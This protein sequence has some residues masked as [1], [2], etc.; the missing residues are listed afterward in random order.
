[1][2]IISLASGTREEEEDRRKACGKTLMRRCLYTFHRFGSPF[3]KAP[4]FP[5]CLLAFVPLPVMVNIF[6]FCVS[7]FVKR[8]GQTGHGQDGQAVCLV[9]LLV[10]Q[11][12]AAW[13]G[14]LP[15]IPARVA[16]TTL[17]FDVCD[18][19]TMDMN[20]KSTFSITP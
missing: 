20:R 3:L 10:F 14:N 13:N 6:I 19:V 5:T 2:R 7:L 17:W 1:M 15:G 9:H 12:C 4:M 11:F 18:I 8:T 16:R